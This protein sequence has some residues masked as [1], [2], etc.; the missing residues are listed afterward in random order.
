MSEEI[1]EAV[2]VSEPIIEESIQEE[3][4]EETV[5]AAEESGEIAEEV[6]EEN[7]EALEQLEDDIE[8]AIENGATKEEVQNMIE[9]FTLK[10]NGKEIKR[11][12][13]LS[14]K[15]AIKREMQLA[16]A[17]R[18]SQQELAEF[19]K[20][21]SSTISDWKN[22][23]DAALKE[24]GLD[25]DE[26]V[27]MKVEAQLAELEKSPEQKERER[28]QREIEE[29]RAEA[30]KKQEELDRIKEEMEKEVYNKKVQEAANQLDE[31]FTAALDAH[32][33][34]PATPRVMKQ[35][36]DTLMW[37]M[38]NAEQIGLDPNDIKLEDVIP[39]V[40]REIRNEFN[41]LLESIGDEALEAFLGQRTLDRLKK[42]RIQ[43]AKKK[44]EKVPSVSSIKASETAK[45]APPKEET[46]KRKQTIDDFLRSR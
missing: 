21:L 4:A 44:T 18:Q 28:V 26:Y 23:P 42:R 1:T 3:V 14:D 2:E 10:V 36:A 27:K 6:M 12:I 29:A 7:A 46:A 38:D 31:E 32:S 33:S 19:K 30:K 39:T 35:L 16:Y 34:L 22:N 13:D 8:E 5:E 15:E 9:E 43:T 45:T 20:T 24:L 41:Q 37:S 40:E 11:S 25:P 17:G